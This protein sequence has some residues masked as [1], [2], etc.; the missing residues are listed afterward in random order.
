MSQLLARIGDEL[1]PL[2]KA[3]WIRVNPQGCVVGS[4]IGECAATP[5]Q[6]HKE[7]TTRA[8]ERAKET[9]QGYTHRLVTKAEWDATARPCI[10]GR[11]E[12]RQA[13]S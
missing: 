8:A 6:A 3:F 2:N 4:C 7:F 12:H 11:C 1:V 5:E 13:A 9:R 10:T